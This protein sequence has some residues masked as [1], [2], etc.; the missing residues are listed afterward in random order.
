MIEPEAAD[1]VDLY[2][3]D[4][5]LQGIRQAYL[6]NCEDNRAGSRDHP[7]DRLFHIRIAQSSGNPVYGMIMGYLLGHRYG[8]MF[9]SLQARYTPD[10]MPN[11]SEA[12]HLAILLALEK[13]DSKRLIWR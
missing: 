2:A 11:I 9:R 1:I 13:R 4:Q 5:E 8:S 3:R 12:E 10:D 7:R 6:Q